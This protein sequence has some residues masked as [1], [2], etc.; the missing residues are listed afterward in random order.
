MAR[1]SDNNRLHTKLSR[2]AYVTA[3]T[4]EEMRAPVTSLA[5]N[6]A[7]LR[8]WLRCGHGREANGVGSTQS[9][10]SLGALPLTQS[11]IDDPTMTNLGGPALRAFFNIAGCWSLS[12]HEQLRMLGLVNRPALRRW[13]SL[14]QS[15]ASVQVSHDTLERISY[16]LGIYKAIN[17]LLQ[18]PDRADNWMRAGNAAP[19]LRWRLGSRSDDGWERE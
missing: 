1:R 11:T 2:L 9:G 17:I 14:A 7:S 15:G 8:N 19:V 10:Q 16:V 5:T 13:K 6:C 12:E 4:F 3:P 18:R